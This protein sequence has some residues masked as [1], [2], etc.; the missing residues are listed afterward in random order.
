[1]FE[2]IVILKKLINQAVPIIDL[3]APVKESPNGIFDNRY[4][5]TCII[6]FS[7]N[8]TYWTKYS[9][10]K[11]HPING[12]YL[13]AIHNKYSRCGVYDEINRQVL[14]KYLEK[15]KEQKLTDQIIDSSFIANKGGSIKKNNYLLSDKAKQKNKKIRKHNKNAPKNKR[16]R[17]ESF[18]DY[19]RYNG[20]KKYFKV[21]TLT[22]S[23][24]T[25][26]TSVIVSS[27]QSDSISLIETVDNLN[28]NLNTLRNSKVNRYKQ[29]LLADPQYD[30]KKNK[31]YLTKLGYKPFIKYN[32]RNTKNKKTIKNNQFNKQEEQ[33]YK[34][35]LRIESFFSWIKNYPTI[36]QNYQKSIESYRGLLLLASTIII[37]KRI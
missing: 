8:G 24:G 11:D 12:K 14:N 7:S 10:T 33:T 28:V 23:L 27:H 18:I 25:P 16:K 26:L 2:N 17:E 35:R 5:L 31:E 6:D 29:R 32:K 13:N 19:N 36:N 30:T 3:L 20:R 37:S 34:K 21:S 15:G 4:F 22:D 9:G 1:M